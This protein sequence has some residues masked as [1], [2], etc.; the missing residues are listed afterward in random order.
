MSDPDPSP[1]EPSLID[2]AMALFDDGKT[3][4]EAELAFQKSRAGFAANRAKGAIAFGL[5]AF[6]VLH[7]ALIAGVVGLVIA[8]APLIGP[9]GATALVTI[10]LIAAGVFFLLKL[11]GRIEDIREAFSEKS[12]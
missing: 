9:W 10:A 2:D 11:K 1:A 5:A 6:G 7:L 4:A 3:Y 8:L 12:S